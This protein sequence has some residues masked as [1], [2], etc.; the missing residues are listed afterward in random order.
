MQGGY[1]AKSMGLSGDRGEN[2]EREWC[3]EGPKVRDHNNG[4]IQTRAME[5]DLHTASPPATL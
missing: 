4:S 1:N 3:K 2:E 5:R